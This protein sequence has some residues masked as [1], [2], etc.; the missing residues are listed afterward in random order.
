MPFPNK[1]S[2]VMSLAKVPFQYQ[3]N[4]TDFV[5]SLEGQASSGTTTNDNA[6]TGAVGEY[7]TG[8]TTATALTANVTV[9]AASVSLTAGD[10]DVWGVVSFKPAASTTVNP[11]SSGISTTSAVFGAEGTYQ[12][13]YFGGTVFGA[14]ELALGAPVARISLAAPGTVYLVASSG[15]GVSTMTCDGHIFARRVR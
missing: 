11:I 2:L 6:A 1:T 15:F 10:W 5:N 9:N 8:T 4:A 13:L 14:V 3:K 7:L 12:Q